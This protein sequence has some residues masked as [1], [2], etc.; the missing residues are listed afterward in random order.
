[1]NRMGSFTAIGFASVRTNSEVTLRVSDMVGYEGA[2][3]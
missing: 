1:M 3:D 2:S